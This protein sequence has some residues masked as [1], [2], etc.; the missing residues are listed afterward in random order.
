MLGGGAFTD[1]VEAKFHSIP[2]LSTVLVSL[3]ASYCGMY[4]CLAK[5]T[6]EL[7]YATGLD[8]MTNTSMKIAEY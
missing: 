4:H 5:L 3:L 7:L 1:E 8:R 2:V 6:K